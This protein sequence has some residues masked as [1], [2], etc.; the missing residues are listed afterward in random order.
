MP[1][2]PKVKLAVFDI[3]GTVF[4][5][6]LSIELT[7]HLT[8]KGIFP[9]HA[10]QELE[11]DYIA[12]LDRQGAY[13]KYVRQIVSVLIKYLPGQDERILQKI[14]DQILEEQKHHVYRYT[15]DLI[16]NL[17]N[18]GYLLIAISG[19]ADFLV[20]KFAKSLGFE[21][22]FGSHFIVKNKKFTGEA[23]VGDTNKFLVLEKF[24]KDNN[25]NIDWKNSIAV[26]DTETDIPMLEAVGKAIA[27]NPNVELAK[28]AQKRGWKIVVERKDV[29]YNIKKFTFEK[30]K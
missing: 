23:I 30:S 28:Y 11:K 1:K 18:K 5:S 25:L 8:E 16:N 20:N 4:R 19:S 27:F 7:H 15:R 6:S 10:W 21:A 3:D 22:S 2:Q 24:A 9:K 26:G 17:K 14:A 12:W 29:I 13:K